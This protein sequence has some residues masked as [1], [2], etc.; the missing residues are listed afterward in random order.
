MAY[1]MRC[2]TDLGHKDLKI[3]AR[4]PAIKRGVQM[5]TE[6][7]RSL[8]ALSDE[9]KRGMVGT[10]Y[11]KFDQTCTFGF[12][13]PFPET[14]EGRD[15]YLTPESDFFDDC[16]DSIQQKIDK[17]IEFKDPKTKQGLKP[18]I[19]IHFKVESDIQSFN[20]YAKHQFPK[21]KKTDICD[22]PIKYNQDGIQSVLK[23]HHLPSKQLRKQLYQEY[24]KQQAAT[25][26]LKS[27]GI[28]VQDIDK[29]LK[30]HKDFQKYALK[31][32]EESLSLSNQL[33]AHIYDQRKQK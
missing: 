32:E 33:S 12:T 17:L 6:I 22:R 21:S 25:M 24:L 31:K 11:L 10:P 16:E 5:V 27:Q 23:P 20:E 26:S 14:N 18:C 30:F 9:E 1:A 4:G 19:N 13:N 8:K 29:N 15:E 28:T 7:E 3:L 2:F